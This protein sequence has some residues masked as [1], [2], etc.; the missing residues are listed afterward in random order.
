MVNPS[1]HVSARKS[2]AAVRAIAIN[3]K[4]NVPEAGWPIASR[5]H[6][7]RIRRVRVS[8]WRSVPKNLAE[9]EPRSCVADR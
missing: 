9:L 5:A 8:L 7:P 4:L 2:A 3:N 1:V 6:L